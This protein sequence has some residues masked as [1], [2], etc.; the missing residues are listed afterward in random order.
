MDH[1]PPPVKATLEFPTATLPAAL[2]I[3]AA[4]SYH[5]TPGVARKPAK[6]NTRFKRRIA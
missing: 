2:P 3:A 4:H 5:L 6:R 1:L